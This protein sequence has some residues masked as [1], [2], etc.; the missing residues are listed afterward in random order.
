MKESTSGIVHLVDDDS[1]FLTSMSRLLRASG[2]EVRTFTSASS[3]LNQ[4]TPE[5]M[6]CVGAEGCTVKQVTEWS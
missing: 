6:S 1:S 2:Y 3:F 4:L 5:A